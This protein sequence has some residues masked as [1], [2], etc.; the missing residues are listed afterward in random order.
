MDAC[1]DNTYEHNGYCVK[2]CPNTYKID[3]KKCVRNV[4][5]IQLI[6]DER[7]LNPN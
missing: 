2:V 3:N 1:P 4:E 6:D 7:V 5:Y